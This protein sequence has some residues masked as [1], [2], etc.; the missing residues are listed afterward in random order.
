M[1]LD[2]D[3][4]LSSMDFSKILIFFSISICSVHSSKLFN[5]LKTQ[6]ANSAFLKN[7]AEIELIYFGSDESLLWRF[8]KM[9]KWYDYKMHYLGNNTPATQEKLKNHLYTLSGETVVLVLNSDCAWI[10]KDP[11]QLLRTLSKRKDGSG[12]ISNYHQMKHGLNLVST[13]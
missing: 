3:I 9:A 6:H 13:S 7:T 4:I 8:E 10:N 1:A 5:K 11:K 2:I 12:I